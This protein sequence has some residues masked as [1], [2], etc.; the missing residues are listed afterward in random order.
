MKVGNQEIEN[1]NERQCSR[2]EFQV[3]EIRREVQKVLLNLV[4]RSDK[5]SGDIDIPRF[6][7]PRCSNAHSTLQYRALVI[8][9]WIHPSFINRNYELLACIFSVNENTLRK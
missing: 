3:F 2:E 5:G 7:E 4:G 6:I 8:A 1:L 9:F